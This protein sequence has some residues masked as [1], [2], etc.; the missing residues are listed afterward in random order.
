MT[1]QIPFRFVLIIIIIKG[2]GLGCSQALLLPRALRSP[3]TLFGA[4]DTFV[5]ALSRRWM[6]I[7]AWAQDRVVA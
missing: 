4:P 1:P 6:R 2:S 7:D 5:R 3:P